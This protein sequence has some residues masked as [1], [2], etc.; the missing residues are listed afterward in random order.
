MVFPLMFRSLEGINPIILF[1]PALLPGAQVVL[2]VQSDSGSLA[3]V[4]TVEGQTSGLAGYPFGGGGRAR[5]VVH[6]ALCQS[7]LFSLCTPKFEPRPLPDRLGKK[8]EETS[9]KGR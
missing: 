2:C 6:L 4:R 3:S 8:E 5:L 9:G 7:G 1:S